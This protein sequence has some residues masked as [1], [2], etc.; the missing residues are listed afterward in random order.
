MDD[1]NY[2]TILAKLDA[3]EK[4]VTILKQQNSHPHDNVAFLAELTTTITGSGH[5]IYFDNVKLN[6]GN[7]Y[8]PHHGMERIYF[9]SP[10][11]R[12]VVIISSCK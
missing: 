10:Y 3:L 5:H 7:A 6:Q 8:N 4:E 12:M 2:Y 11:V 1:N 9:L